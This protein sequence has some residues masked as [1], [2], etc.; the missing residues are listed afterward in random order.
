MLALWLA[1]Q[2]L[3]DRTSLDLRDSHPLQVLTHPA[4]P[5]NVKLNLP[6]ESVVPD[7]GRRHEQTESQEHSEYLLVCEARSTTL[8]D[9]YWRFTLETADGSLV[10]DADDIEVGDLNRLTLLAAVRG[11]ESI[12]GPSSVTLLSNNR[13]L[14]RSLADSLPRWR[15]NGF[16]WENFGRRVDVQHADL[17][18]RIDRALAIHRVE[19]CLISTRLV[20]A[21]PDTV[22]DFSRTS[23]GGSGDTWQRI[24]SAHTDPQTN[25]AAVPAP[26]SSSDR[27]RR[28]LLS[29]DAATGATTPQRRFTAQ[30]LLESA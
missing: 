12:E 29:G 19:A 9:G 1:G 4:G 21:G 28:W 27:L 7:D 24:D 26:K 17:W 18:R 6:N 22:G 3:M 11:L 10:L 8:T 13:Y 16:V 15:Q 5:P 25:R 20:S 14:I 30:D 2:L 23:A